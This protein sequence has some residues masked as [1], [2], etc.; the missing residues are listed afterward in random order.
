MNSLGDDQIDQIGES[1]KKM[2][3]NGHKE[4]GDKS[5]RTQLLD[6]PAEVLSQIAS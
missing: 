6:L 5:H 1:V 3:L 2:R 4:E